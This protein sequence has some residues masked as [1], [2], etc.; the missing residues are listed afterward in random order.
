MDLVHVS[1]SPTPAATHCSIMDLKMNLV[2]STVPFS[3]NNLISHV[4]APYQTLAHILDAFCHIIKT[5]K[6][7]YA[8]QGYPILS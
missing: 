4:L 7:L 8:I 2:P 1:G 3:T 6:A 5:T